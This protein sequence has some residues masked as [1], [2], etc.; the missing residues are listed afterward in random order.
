MPK[1]YVARLVFDKNHRSMI[2]LKNGKVVGGICFRPFYEQGFAEIAFCAITGNEQVKGYGSR[3]MNHVKNFCIA[4]GTP[5]TLA[6][7]V[8]VPIEQL[9]AAI[10]S[11]VLAWDGEMSNDAKRCYGSLRA[12]TVTDGILTKRQAQCIKLII[13]DGREIV[14]TPDHKVRTVSRGWVRAD[15][16]IIGLDRV[17]IAPSAPLDDPT[18]AELNLEQTFSLRCDD[19]VFSMISRVERL[20]TLAFARIL[21]FAMAED[22]M[23]FDSGSHRTFISVN[24]S[25]DA[26]CLQ[27][28]IS[29]VCGNISG[30]ISGC[31]GR[32]YIE[33]PTSLLS[34]L[35][36]LGVK[37]REKHVLF[38]P[39]VPSFLQS[40]TCPKSVI[41]EFLAGFFGG[42]GV[43]P[44]I[45]RQGNYCE[46]LHLQPVKLTFANQKCSGMMLDSILSLLARIGVHSA[47]IVSDDVSVHHGGGMTLVLRPD[48][49][50]ARFVGFR[51]SGEKAIRL[52][53]ATAWWSM[54]ERISSSNYPV[55]NTS[56]PITCS[57]Q[58]DHNPG[59]KTSSL[60]NF[61][62]SIG[63]DKWFK[64]GNGDA[65]EQSA[66][67]PTFAL[68]VV[69]RQSTAP[70]DV[71]DLSVSEMHSFLANGIVV[72]NCQSIQILRFLTYADNYAIGYFKKQGFT[73]EVTLEDYRHRGY[74]K[75]YDGGTLMECVTRV[76]IDYLDIPDM[77]KEQR[78]AVY[79]KIKEISNSHIVYEGLDVFRAGGMPNRIE[80][81]PGVKE[82]GWKPMS[83][84][85]ER[86][87][88]ELQHK[89]R[90][91]FD[92]VRSHEDAWP[93]LEP[94]DTSVCGYAFL[95]LLLLR[96]AADTFHDSE[97]IVSDY[98]DVVKEPIDMSEIGRRLDRGFYRTHHIFIAD[99]R[100]LFDNCRLYNREQT[101]YYACANNVEEFFKSAMK[102]HV[103]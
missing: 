67:L 98:L 18:I 31:N 11:N 84:T 41:R 26:K 80:D 70:T 82:A 29:V 60:L 96:T 65:L 55:C 69:S 36:I 88:Q 50:F 101:E 92:E 34:A 61:F 42:N 35:A 22:S 74:I 33:I 103:L 54:R 10:G 16:L 58:D 73:K 102:R 15:E 90:I 86:E 53:A 83:T 12:A 38:A 8:A 3:L 5:V 7:G 57:P 87:I 78:K 66:A 79:E 39:S 59:S 6:S 40:S 100:R 1:E 47:H 20:R 9:V 85:K 13:E 77:I 68:R 51:Y 62:A 56:L 89:L 49:D 63:A 64:D 23:Q 32:I 25:Y 27:S 76:G 45:V 52:G 14:L 94:V 24:T 93:F 75:D 44:M 71:F 81:I 28:D 17:L 95:S 91:V 99:F 19:F 2:G 4:R 30:N 43:A 46:D 97:Q 72:H 48:A 21:G 37:S